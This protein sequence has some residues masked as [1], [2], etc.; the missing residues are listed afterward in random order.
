MLF[1]RLAVGEREREREGGKMPWIDKLMCC[2]ETKRQETET[3]RDTE[4]QDAID[5]QGIVLQRDERDK[6]QEQRVRCRTMMWRLK[7]WNGMRT[8]KLSH[9]HVLVVISSRLPRYTPPPPLWFLLFSGSSFLGIVN[10]RLETQLTT[11]FALFFLREPLWN[12]NPCSRVEIKN[13]IFMIVFC[14]KI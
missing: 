12:W 1:W 6:N 5:W 3:A 10:R 11:C 4:W 13:F 7:T 9:T 2:R 14:R 8:S